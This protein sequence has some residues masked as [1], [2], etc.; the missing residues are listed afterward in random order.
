MC[1]KGGRRWVSRRER[2][3]GGYTMVEGSS[4]KVGEEKLLKVLLFPSAEL[5]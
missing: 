5:L 4:E 2:E 3:T 1:G